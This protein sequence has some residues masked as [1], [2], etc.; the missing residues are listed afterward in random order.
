MWGQGFPAPTF[1]DDFE[2]LQQRIVGD[3]HLKLRLRK[4]DGEFE[5]MLFGSAQPAARH[6]C[7]RS[8]A[9]P[10]TNT[11]ATRR[12]QLTSSTGTQRMT[13]D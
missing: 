6:G 7:T 11:T 8:T 12:L 4:D 5:A 1:C 9:S 13:N 2:V 3:R 10:S